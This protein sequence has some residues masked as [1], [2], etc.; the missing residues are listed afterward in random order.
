MLKRRVEHD[1]KRETMTLVIM[2]GIIVLVALAV[3]NWLVR[4]LHPP[5][6]STEMQS[7]PLQF[8]LKMPKVSF[9]EGEPVPLELT[10]RNTSSESVTLRFDA[11]SEYDFVVQKDLNLLVLTVPML[12]WTWSASHPSGQGVHRRALGPG[13]AVTFRAEWPQVDSHGDA[14][15]TGQ[16]TILG[17]VNLAGKER[18]TLKIR[19]QNDH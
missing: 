14:V 17:T 5:V 4:W 15:G 11:G 9:R 2:I 7:G 16:Y 3:M 12:V 18:Q 6:S 10:V 8:S 1:P 19:G 13:S